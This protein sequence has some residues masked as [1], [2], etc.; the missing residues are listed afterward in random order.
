MEGVTEQHVSRVAILLRTVIGD[1][2]TGCLI[3]DP[4]QRHHD[5]CLWMSHQQK[6]EIF[7]EEAWRRANL[8]EIWKDV[9]KTRLLQ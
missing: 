3:N 9:I 4:S 8:A 6:V 5:V 2:C 1:I 7:F